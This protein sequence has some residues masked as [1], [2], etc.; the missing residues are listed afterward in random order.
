MGQARVIAGG[1]RLVQRLRARLFP[2]QFILVYHKVGHVENDPWGLTVS[3]DNF[4]QQLDTLAA[5]APCFTIAQMAKALTDGTLPRR[6]VAI[7]F[8]DGYADN[9][10]H[11]M[12]LLAQRNMNA[13]LFLAPGLLGHDREFWWDELER[14]LFE[15]EHLPDHLELRIAGQSFDFAISQC[16]AKESIRS[17]RAWSSPIGPRTKLYIQLWK[18]LKPIS[19]DDQIEA[20][21]ALLAWTGTSCAIRPSHRIMTRAEAVRLAQARVFEIGAHTMRHVS[22]PSHDLQRQRHE[23]VESKAACSQIA[24]HDVSSISYPYGDYDGQTARLVQEAGFEAAC[25]TRQTVLPP[26]CDLFRLP[27]IQAH[28]WAGDDLAYQISAFPNEIEN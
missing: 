21:E 18:L 26:H 7:T 17:W 9:L 12:P 5:F 4:A 13:T 1:Q 11:A 24:E 27:R 14:C 8:D 16:D 10:Y 23:L 19:H 15:P 25:T 22:L 6:A 2:R 28:D 20:L 3:P